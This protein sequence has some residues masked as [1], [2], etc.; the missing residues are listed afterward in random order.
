MEALATVAEQPQTIGHYRQSR[1]SLKLVQNRA[2]AEAIQASELAHDQ[3]TQARFR[4]WQ[5]SIAVSK[6]AELEPD[7]TDLLD[8]IRGADAEPGSEHDKAL[9]INIATAVSEAM[10]KYNYVG[11]KIFTRRN[12][13]G[14]RIQH[15]QSIDS[16]GANAVNLRPKRHPV[17]EAITDAENLNGFRIDDAA[18]AEL[19]KDSYFLVWSLVPKNVPEENLGHKGDGYFL[20]YL[21]VSI[22][23]TTEEASGE[24][25]TEAAFAKGVENGENLTFEDRMAMR[26]DFEALAHVFKQLGIKLPVQQTAEGYLQAS[27]LVP[28]HLMRNGVIDALRL[29][30]EASDEVLGREVVRTDEDYLTIQAESRR[31]EASLASVRE[32]VKSDLIAQ[33]DS[34]SSAF[35]ATQLLWELVKRH[36]VQESFTNED[37]DPLVFGQS[38]APTILKARQLISDNDLYAAFTY[39]EQAQKEAVI[40][41]CGGGSD[42]SK[43]KSSVLES[44]VDF[45]RSGRDRFGSLTFRCK[46]GHLNEREPGELLDKCKTCDGKV[47][48]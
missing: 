39:M 16:V 15:T 3:F 30:H 34:L 20:D 38:A 29:F 33:K 1:P 6:T 8:M 23:A 36:G 2:V 41:G 18:K 17:L 11:E 47:K 48:C 31:K 7:S 24:I 37:I 21:S 22:Q 40:T 28:K 35:E 19:L 12:E 9:D 26:H 46:K 27:A 45:A 14:K 43:N 4:R 32:K 13:L 10:F 25:S 44:A 5:G 42:A